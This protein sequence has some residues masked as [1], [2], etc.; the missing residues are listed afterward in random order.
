MFL[1]RMKIYEMFS[2]RDAIYVI[3]NISRKTVCVY[4]IIS[5]IM[6]YE[7]RLGPKHTKHLQ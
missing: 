6:V 5:N 7:L 1:S 2:P 3:C 4:A